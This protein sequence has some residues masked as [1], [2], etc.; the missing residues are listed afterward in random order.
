[1][2]FLPHPTRTI[3]TR[4]SGIIKQVDL[5]CSKNNTENHVHSKFCKFL[6]LTLKSPWF[7]ASHNYVA[8]LGHTNLINIFREVL[9]FLMARMPF[10]L[11]PEWV[12]GER[13]DP[14]REAFGMF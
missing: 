4:Y 14:I 7:H 11:L 9:R 12:F 3:V 1:M 5:L 6:K 8:C 2:Q 10:R 13:T